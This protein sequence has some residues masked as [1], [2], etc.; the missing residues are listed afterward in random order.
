MASFTDA[1]TQFNPYVAQ[2]PVDAMVKVG[3]QKQAQY[4]QGVQKIQ[5]QIDQVAG[6]DVLRDVDKNYLQSKLNELGGKLRG[7]AAGD[8]SNFQLVNSVA[9]MTKQVASDEY[10]QAAVSSASNHR[11]QRADMDADKKKGTLTPDNEYNYNKQLSAYL[12]SKDLKSKDGSPIT[13]SG[14]YIPNFDVF[15]FA[16]ETFDA[17]KPDGFSFD[18]VYITDTNGNPKRGADGQLIYSPVMVRME[19][20]GIFP[21]K[22]KQ[23]L[24]QIFSDPRVSQQLAISGQYNYRGLDSNALSQRV[25]SQKAELMNSYDEKLK[26]LTVQKNLGKDVQKDIDD[27]KL[28]M[29]NVNTTYDEY[30][31]LATENPDAVR[32]QLYKDDVNARYTTMFGW[33]KKKEQQMENPGWNANFKL[34]Q[35]ANRVS[36]FAQRLAFDK[37]KHADEMLWKQKTYDQEE[38]KIDKESG[39]GA[40]SGIDW[41]L[42]DQASSIDVINKVESDY[43]KAATNFKSSSTEFIWATAFSGVDRN[44][45]ELS[46]RV[47]KGMSESAAKMS[48]IEENAKRNNQTVEEFIAGWGNYGVKQYNKMSQAERDKLPSLKDAYS[49][50]SNA[51]TNFDGMSSVKKTLDE[52]YQKELGQLANVA[53]ITG[54]VPKEQV[55]TFGG[56]NLKL[57]KEQVYDMAVYLRGEKNTAN[58]M[59][60]D[61]IKTASKTAYKRLEAAGLGQL[62]NTILNNHTLAKGAPSLISPLAPFYSDTPDYLTLAVRGTKAVV[63]DLTNPSDKFTT[64]NL[65]SQVNDVYGKLNNEQYAGALDRKAEII[66][67]VYGI[68]GNKKANLLTGEDKIDKGTLF[69]LRGFA[70]AYTDGQKMNLSPDFDKFAKSITDGDL[71]DMAI[72]A[73]VY[74]D[75]G[76]NP[77]IEVI[78]YD[79]NGERAG[80]MTIQPDEALKMG[81]DIN[82]IYEPE[83]VGILRNKINTKGG[84]T[85]DGDPKLTSTYLDGDVQYDRSFFPAIQGSRYDLKANIVYS[86]GL[87]YPYVYASDGKVDDVRELPGS[88]DLHK[89]TLSLKQLNSDFAQAIL[90]NK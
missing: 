75:R 26:E 72:T 12:D 70:G 58:Y 73:N 56:K 85:S 18:Q 67:E 84:K 6:L 4:E 29:S 50:Y 5:A 9:G 30:A 39:K 65:L 46:K 71:K 48:I 63:R 59:E 47:A 23:T 10:V 90:N 7:Y 64:M 36:E 60:S 35:E 34:N 87:Y 44:N 11:K 17:V 31:K 13:F 14:K 42:Q 53:D 86:N 69:S 19:K 38:R 20:E 40:L 2:L 78:S 25:M 88:D 37:R 89:L 76:G 55:V 81:I 8:F 3:M 45:V 22:V 54:G 61:S 16:K 51:R 79:K 66:K 21:D 57:T 28:R 80:G 33:M 83:E 49:S 41:T 82:Q 77:Q 1:I 43:E 15:K 24:G 32:G 27:V 74:M 52:R 68:R 62:A